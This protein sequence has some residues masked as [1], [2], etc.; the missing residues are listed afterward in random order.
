MER[1]HFLA[2][3]PAAIQALGAN[4]RVN[5]VVMGLG[6]RGMDHVRGLA[7]VPGTRISGLCDA[8]QART[9]RMA[10]QV[11]RQQGSTPKTY[12]QLDD[13]LADKEVDAIA[14]ATCNHWHALATIRACQAGK[15]VYLEKPASHNV[16][17]GRKMVEAARKYGRIVQVGHQSR[18]LSHIA[19]AVE[20]VRT[21][22]IGK[23]YMA[24][25][26]CFRR[27]ES[28]GRK[29]DSPT[30]PGVDYSYWLGPAPM[31]PFNPNRFH[32][33]W[34][35]FW[36]TGNGD[37]G[38]QGVHQ[39]DIARWVL[40]LDLPSRVVS[41][42][43]KFVWDDDQETPNTLQTVFEYPACELTFEVRNLPSNNEGVL[44]RRGESFIGNIFYGSEGYLEVDNAGTRL[45]RSGRPEPE[46]T[47]LPSERGEQDT[48]RHIENFVAA[49]RSRDHRQL[50]CDVEQGHLSAALAHLA[51]IS[52]RTRK[53]LDFDPR[54]ERFP[55][56][57][58]ANALLRRNYRAPYVIS[59]KV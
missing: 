32:Y 17:E 41:S 53:K 11:L 18:S 34:H 23:V 25:G 50:R 33:N 1:R 7:K 45:Y 15:D 58:E 9:E 47:I 39:L 16:W 56:N 35:W 12:R 8:D 4:D 55:G 26:I 20:L 14:M 6:G 36:D 54:S 49:M 2:A 13:I 3:A 24:R 37:I 31:R 21:G 42:G 57:D 10:Q 59:E 22:A 52:Y 38:N 46:Q 19:R 29:P 40:G 44:Q 27:R 43:G 30:P 48:V 28:I 5:V 51:N